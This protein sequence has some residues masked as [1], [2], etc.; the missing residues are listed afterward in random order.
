MFEDGLMILVTHGLMAL[1]GVGVGWALCD[2]RATRQMKAFRIPGP[3]RP[4]QPI[5]EPPPMANSGGCNC[6]ANEIGA[7][8]RH[9]TACGGPGS[10]GKRC[11]RCDKRVTSKLYQH[12]DPFFCSACRAEVLVEAELP[13]PMEPQTIKEGAV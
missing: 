8:A 3:V 11:T 5:P 9:T 10:E 1:I 7:G 6:G 12:E 4:T 13:P 2:I